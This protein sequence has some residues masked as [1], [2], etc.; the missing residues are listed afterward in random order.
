MPKTVRFH[1]NAYHNEYGFFSK[2]RVYTDIPDDFKLPSGSE[3]IDSPTEMD[4]V[5][6]KNFDGLITSGINKDKVG[7]KEVTKRNSAGPK[8][9]APAKKRAS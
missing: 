3:E 9:N 7:G 1:E 8:R 4:N 5:T 6:S 2:D